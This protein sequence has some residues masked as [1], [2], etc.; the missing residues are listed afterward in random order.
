MINDLTQI[1]S[2]SN[3]ATTLQNTNFNLADDKKLKETCQEFEA[4]FVKQMLDSMNKTINKSGLIK[5]NMG[6]QIFNDMLTDEYSKKISDASGFGIA[7]M[8]YKQLAV[9]KYQ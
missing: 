1:N 2:V 9:K 5:E 4:M 8:M 6:E 7:E 3:R